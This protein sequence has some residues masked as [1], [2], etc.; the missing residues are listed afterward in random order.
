MKRF[1]ACYSSIELGR[2]VPAHQYADPKH[3][4]TEFFGYLFHSTPEL[5]AQ[6]LRS[7]RS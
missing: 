1:G 4:S 5:S 6:R 2:I 3:T 7:L